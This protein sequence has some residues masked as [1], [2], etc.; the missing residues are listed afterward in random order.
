MTRNYSNSTKGRE[1]ES[2]A[3]FYQSKKRM[4][5]KNAGLR[6][7][8]KQVVAPKEILGSEKHKDVKPKISKSR[9]LKVS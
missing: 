1:N 9:H 7:P 4:K 2:I 5:T 8:K 3:K 6:K